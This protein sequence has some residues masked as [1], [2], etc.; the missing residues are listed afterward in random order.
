[1]SEEK[2]PDEVETPKAVFKCKDENCTK[3]HYHMDAEAEKLDNVTE[4]PMTDRQEVEV[5]PDKA[6]L[7]KSK[8]T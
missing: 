7:N 4:E 1:M 8:S 6:D 5:T 2:P 3:P